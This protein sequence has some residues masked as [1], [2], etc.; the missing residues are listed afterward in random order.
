MSS[1]TVRVSAAF[2]F[3]AE[4]HELATSVDLDRVAQEDGAAPD[5]HLLLARAHGIDPYSY[6]YEV[7]ESHELEFAAATGLA[8]QCCREG[9]FDWACFVRLRDDAR[10]LPVVRRIAAQ[11]LEPAGIALTD[12]IEAALLAAYRAGK[13]SR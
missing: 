11:L 9:V 2:S 5:F 12:T 6:L 7:L 13:T 1:N 4:N 8:A 3:K 10:D